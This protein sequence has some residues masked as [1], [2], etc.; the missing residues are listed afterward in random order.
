MLNLLVCAALGSVDNLYLFF[1]P[2][3]EESL[4]MGLYISYMLYV[5][6]ASCRLLRMHCS[7]A[8]C[9]PFSGCLSSVYRYSD[10][11][12]VEQRKQSHVEETTESIESLALKQQKRTI[13]TSAEEEKNP[14]IVYDEQ[15]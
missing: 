7:D 5:E 2:I 9:A 14:S 6:I 1:M 10:T 8:R 11:R 3:S 15:Q 4:W 13:Y 12:R